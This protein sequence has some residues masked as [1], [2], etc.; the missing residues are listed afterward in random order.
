MLSVPRDSI[1]KKDRQK[2]TYVL[3]AVSTKAMFH[4][5]LFR[6]GDP[7]PPLKW[8]VLDGLYRLQIFQWHLIINRSILH[9]HRSTNTWIIHQMYLAI[10]IMLKARKIGGQLNETEQMPHSGQ[11]MNIWCPLHLFVRRF[12]LPFVSVANQEAL[13]HSICMNYVVNLIV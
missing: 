4:R 8:S 7:Q 12:T 5:T 13:C 9:L 10:S 1:N 11:V 3:V 2:P 6:Q